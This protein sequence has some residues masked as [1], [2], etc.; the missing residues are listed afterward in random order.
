MNSRSTWLWLA[1]AV[2]LFSFIFFFERHLKKDP[3]GPPHVLPAFN[4][5][6]IRSI[7]VQPKGQRAILVER[8]NGVWQMLEPIPYPANSPQIAAFLNALQHLTASPYLSSQEL[9]NI[10]EADTQFGFNSPQCSLMLN[11]KRHLVLIGNRTPPGDRVYLQV[12]GIDGVF[13]VSADVLRLIPES[14]SL[15]RETALADW[16]NLKFNRIVVTNAGKQLELQLNATNQTWRML[17]PNNVRADGAKVSASIMQLVQARAQQFVTDDPS[18]DLESMGLMPPE[19]SLALMH[20]TNAALHFDIGKSPAN[21]TNLVYARRVG[22]NA[23]LT[24][25]KSHFEPWT[26][27]HSHAFRDF[28][29]PHLIVLSQLPVSIEIQADE[30]FMLERSDGNSWRVQPQGYLADSNLMAQLFQ[31]VTN[32]QVTSAQIEKDIVPAADLP[33]YGLSQPFRQYTFKANPPAGIETNIVLAQLEFGTNQDKVFARVPG[34]SFV[35]SVPPEML[36]Q[37]P[38]ASWQMR[39]RRIWSF[40]PSEVASVKI[41]QKGKTRHVIRKGE[42]SWAP[43]PGSQGIVDQII[44]AQLEEGVLRLGDLSAR[45]WTQRGSENLEPYGFKEADYRITIELKSGKTQSVMFG[46]AAPSEFPFAATEIEGETW[47]FEFPWDTFQFVQ[48]FLSASDRP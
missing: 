36:D 24:V 28:F 6:E 10:P 43:A 12:V 31:N 21:N 3:A 30:R 42:N 48:L 5:A 13:V 18:A 46:G 41:E 40:K 11:Q 39:D 47:V 17:S 15:W 25:P 20:G 26:S 23:I 14:P 45:F 16:V 44:S 29:D 34:E 35:Y 27:S 9:K 2:C 32:L 33:R 8:T 38:V 1:S 4:P 22:H 19:L 37:L 7:Q